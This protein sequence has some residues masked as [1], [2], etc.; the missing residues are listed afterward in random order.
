[1]SWFRRPAPPVPEPAPEP[2]L[3]RPVLEVTTDL[4]VVR[5]PFPPG[6]FSPGDW[7]SFC[8]RLYLPDGHAFCRRMFTLFG[9][10]R[11][12]IEVPEAEQYAERILGR[13]L[14]VDIHCAWRPDG[15]H[16]DATFWLACED[17]IDWRP[18]YRPDS[19]T[20]RAVESMADP[21]V[22]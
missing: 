5:Y 6:R 15:P 8:M 7:Q 13:Y 4:G 21:Y 17:G 18:E 10:Q 22:D 16:P 1:M 12:E 2:E 3:P 19:T 20:G 11:L 14:Q 9:E